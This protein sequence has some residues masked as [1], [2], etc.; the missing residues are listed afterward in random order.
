MSKAPG[1][2]EQKKAAALAALL[3]SETLSAAAERAGISR[4]TLYNYIR[5]DHEFSLAY[6]G[7]MEEAAAGALERLQAQETRAAEVVSAILEDEE[8]PAGIRLKAAHEI[9]AAAARQRETV[10]TMA[11]ENVSRTAPLFENLF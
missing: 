10:A 11:A 1:R 7:M 9:I 5:E 4:K 3:E 6:R 2:N 8:Q